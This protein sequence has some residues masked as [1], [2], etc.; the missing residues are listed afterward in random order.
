MITRMV[1]GRLLNELPQQCHIPLDMVVLG[2]DAF[3]S[4]PQRGT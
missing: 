2:D 3:G 4:P 1:I